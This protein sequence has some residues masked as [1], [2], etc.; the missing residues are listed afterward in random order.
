MANRHTPKNLKPVDFNGP[1][2]RL[3]IDVGELS[4]VLAEV[5]LLKSLLIL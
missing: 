2:P 1:A 4:Q 5:S 3:G